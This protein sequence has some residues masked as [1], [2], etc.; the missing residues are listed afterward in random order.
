MI[1][2]GT[3]LTC[4][5]KIFFTILIGVAFIAI[6]FFY[7]SD[8]EKGFK[9]QQRVAASIEEKLG[10]FEKGFLDTSELANSVWPV[11]TLPREH[12]T[13]TTPHL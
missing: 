6:R 7:L 10:L 4:Q 13:I 9:S 2:N 5:Q 11:R 12:K 1:Q 8:L 3:N